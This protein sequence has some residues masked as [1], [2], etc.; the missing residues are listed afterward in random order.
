S[1]GVITA[2]KA[3]TTTIDASVLSVSGSLTSTD[4][5]LSLST[6]RGSGGSGGKK[7]G[8][9]KVTV[10]PTPVSSV[11]MSPATVSLSI[12]A[13]AQIAATPL[14]SSG[15]PLSGR[16]V[17]WSSAN[18][19][20]AT[21]SSTGLVTG[22]AFG[23]TSVI[24]TVDGMQGSAAVNIPV[25]GAS[26][27]VVSPAF[28][29]LMTGQ[30]SQ[31]TAVLKV[32]SGNVISGTSFTWTTSNSS[33]A[34]VTPSSSG[35]TAT[36]SALAAGSASITA[37]AN[38][39]KAAVSVV[40]TLVPVATVSVSPSSLSLTVGQTG[41]FTST[42]R[43]STGGT[44]TGRTAT[45]T[46]SNTGVATVSSGGVVTAV[47]AGT[48]TITATVDGK[49]GTGS[50]SVAAPAPVTSPAP[51]P[52]SPAP[53]DPTSGSGVG[54]SSSLNPTSRVVI[55]PGQSIQAAVD[56]NPEGTTFWLKAG[57]WHQQ[58]I[59][60]KNGQSFIG[61]VGAI[62]D[63]DNVTGQAF[64]SRASNVTIR[65]LIVQHYA[66]PVQDGAIR[67]DWNSSSHWTVDHNEV[68]SNSGGAGIYV[69]DSSTYT[70]NYVHDNGQFGLMGRGS[71]SV[72]S[73][74]EIAH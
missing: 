4:T 39:S 60:P 29:S 36:I 16:T 8:H 11:L 6:N 25:V 38:G 51:T 31:E 44:L 52:T 13:T 66:P 10:S 72:V 7:I 48:A 24:A 15:K 2:L 12:G 18:N 49:S 3:G 65:N 71:G 28:V 5:L 17:T 21:V 64:F 20:V 69:V 53:S 50:V 59:A 46:S 42:A 58:N 1:S 37:A 40:V 73:N 55:L 56:A 74:N 35:S 26:V 27:P 30:T 23:S 45:W 33:V 63:G 43:D 62:L 67:G 34:K 68:R 70:A 54:P 41:T 9:V 14:D 47:A 57:T 22:V 32:A 61:E 19:A